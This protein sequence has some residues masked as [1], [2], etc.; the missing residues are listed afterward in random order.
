MTQFRNDLAHRMN[1]CAI[2]L[3]EHKQTAPDMI[4]QAQDC[5]GSEAVTPGDK[6]KLKLVTEITCDNKNEIVWAP[7][8]L[9][10]D[11]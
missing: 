7:K 9:D 5:E 2:P 3:T 11:S 4:W 10:N 6:A 1:E 8:C